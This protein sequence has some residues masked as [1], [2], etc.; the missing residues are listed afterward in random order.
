MDGI[1]NGFQSY[2]KRI[3]AAITAILI[4]IITFAEPAEKPDYYEPLEVKN[5]VIFD[6]L[7]RA[8]GI[9]TDG[10]HFFFSEN[11]GLIK[12][13]LN[14]LDIVAKNLIAIPKEL[15]DLGCKHIGG[16]SYYNGRVYV[17]IEDSKVF[18]HLYL[19]MFDAETLELIKYEAV[20]LEDHENGI[21][22][23]AVDK[24][25]GIL[26]SARRD[27]ITTLN[28][29]DAETLK[30]IDKFEIDAPVHKVQGA[31]I[32]NG[33]IYMSVSRDDQAIYA[34]NLATGQVQKVISR[35]LAGETEGEGMTILPTENGAFFHVLDI[36][37]MRINV[38][39]RSY[40]FD[41]DSLV[42]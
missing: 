2:F 30:P 25:T 27:H 23:V 5:F 41:P 35:N 14:G 29:Y 33:V 34:A 36:G 15:L 40:A 3:I 21:P 19:A 10:E 4:S 17:S 20:P 26:Y 7:I 24:D 39:L 22:W 8:Q 32:H 37:D 31:E 42:W 11:Y 6:A 38:H 28:M 18:E 13:E 16:I 1:I 12:T 9:T